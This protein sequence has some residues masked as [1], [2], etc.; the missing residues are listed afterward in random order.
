M[1]MTCGSTITTRICSPQM[2]HRIA[3]SRLITPQI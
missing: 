3:R 2:K 1:S